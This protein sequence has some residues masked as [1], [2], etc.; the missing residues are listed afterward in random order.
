MNWHKVFFVCFV[1]M[2]A[3][4]KIVWDFLVSQPS[5]IKKIFKF[6]V[7]FACSAVFLAY[8]TDCVG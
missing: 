3:D 4:E 8:Q 2:D 7:S 5:E 6:G 1:C